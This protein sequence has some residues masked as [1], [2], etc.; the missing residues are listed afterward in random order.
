MKLQRTNQWDN[1]LD[2]IMQGKN[3]LEGDEEKITT[4]N[5]CEA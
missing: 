3:R 1:H 2:D 4:N 5:P